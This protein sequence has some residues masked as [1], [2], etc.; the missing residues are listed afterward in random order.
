M[1]TV[2]FAGSPSVSKRGSDVPHTRAAS[3]GSESPAVEQPGRR[4]MQK[5]LRRAQTSLDPRRR[6][7]DRLSG[8][9]EGG[10]RRGGG[11]LD[12]HSSASS[13]EGTPPRPIPA[14]H[15]QAGL[16]RQHDQVAGS[17]PDARPALA[18][19]RMSTTSS[20]LSES[21]GVALAGQGALMVDTAD[22][23]GETP[24]DS[25]GV[26]LV[27]A[28]LNYQ[29]PTPL[30]ERRGQHPADASIASL[31]KAKPVTVA[32][33]KP[34]HPYY[35]GSQPVPSS[36]SQKSRIENSES[37]SSIRSETDSH[38]VQKSKFSAQNGNA[39]SDDSRR[40][41][42]ITSPDLA[43]V[44]DLIDVHFN[45]AHENEPESSDTSNITSPELFG[46]LSGR[47]ER[48]AT[49]V[50]PGGILATENGAVLNISPRARTRMHHKQDSPKVR[51][52]IKA[53]ILDF[54]RDSPSPEREDATRGLR[55]EFDGALSQQRRPQ[56]DRVVSGLASGGSSIISTPDDVDVFTDAG[57]L[58]HGG[59]SSMESSYISA[60]ESHPETETDEV[61]TPDSLTSPDKTLLVSGSP[62]QSSSSTSPSGTE[63]HR[64][65]PSSASTPRPHKPVRAEYNV[66]TTARVLGPDAGR[67]S[68]N[69][70]TADYE[71]DNNR[72]PHEDMSKSL[73]EP[74]REVSTEINKHS[75]SFESGLESVGGGDNKPSETMHFITSVKD[76]CLDFSRRLGLQT[77][78]AADESVE[79]ESTSDS[80]IIR[81]QAPLFTEGAAF[82]EKQRSIS[83]KDFYSKFNTWTGG[84]RQRK[85]RRSIGCEQV[86]GFW[87]DGTN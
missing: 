68:R 54:D 51:R 2:M 34:T 52:V 16:K 73:I 33:F 76:M 22:T 13:V 5:L 9:S 83:A 27:A 84:A 61:A 47:A 81:D 8:S 43:E 11:D 63:L 1:R 37:S 87:A 82:A 48:T 86:C 30:V 6:A 15:K 62:A 38:A 29:G 10:L 25:E 3:S 79:T 70:S 85:Q 59:L 31:A 39:V 24:Q 75:V 32:A 7:S 44:L 45:M 20:Q 46:S 65:K 78:A 19:E 40:K 26:G 60:M 58:Q 53:D 55:S 21:G 72:F 4:R 18:A 36:H 67:R 17:S 69:T 49:F 80:G 77:A 74:K 64:T 14:A 28:N 35:P 66:S 23:G 41:D 57:S 71:N 12:S 50:Q 56:A 42:V